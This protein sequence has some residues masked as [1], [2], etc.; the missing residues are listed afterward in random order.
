[1]ILADTGTGP[2]LI[3]TG[4]GVA[5]VSDPVGF[6]V[7]ESLYQVLVTPD[8][9]ETVVV[10]GWSFDHHANASGTRTKTLTPNNDDVV[11]TSD[12]PSV[13]TIGESGGNVGFVSAGTARIKATDGH[14]HRQF[15]VECEVLT[16]AEAYA[17]VGCAEG[18]L[19]EEI[20]ANAQALI[21]AGG[22]VEMFAGGAWN[23]ARLCA[24]IDMTSEKLGWGG[25]SLVGINGTDG[26]VLSANHLSADS[27]IT[28]GILGVGSNL[29]FRAADYSLRTVTITDWRRIGTSDLRLCRVS[30]D[31]TGVTPAEILG[32]D[33][34]NFLPTPTLLSS[35]RV[36]AMPWGYVNQLG[37]FG[38]TIGYVIA[39]DGFSVLG[40]QAL[41]PA[42]IAGFWI[43]IQGGDSGHRRGPIINNKMAVAS[44]NHSTGRIWELTDAIH[45][46]A[47][48]MNSTATVQTVSLS[49][50]TD[51]P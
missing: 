43:K 33:I 9:Q 21:T 44:V 10:D 47:I 7:A 24:G 26:L 4:E 49:G 51:F 50:F 2:A 35:R 41:V 38:L 19:A 3:A 1:M 32:D 30:G 12:D 48:S 23:P 29:Q 36:A 11:F 8:V 31:M 6:N 28:H 20:I 14:Y 18:S 45:A 46:A 40:E 37:Q 17:L 5:V 39:S 34:L 42:G 22:S 27:P 13:G 15:D 16:L 25:G